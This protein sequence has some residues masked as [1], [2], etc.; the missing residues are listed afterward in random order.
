MQIV[1]LLQGLPEGKVRKKITD[2]FKKSIQFYVVYI[3]MG[4]KGPGTA[5]AVLE[6]KNEDRQKIKNSIQID[7]KNVT[8]T[9]LPANLNDIYMF[10]ISDETRKMFESPESVNHFVQLAIK[11]M[12]EVETENFFNNQNRL[13]DVKYDVQ[14]TIDRPEYQVYS[15]GSRDQGLGLKN[16]DCDIFIDTGDMYNGNK[17]QSKEEQE[18][19]I[20]KLFNILKE[21]PVT[22]DELIFIPNARVPIIRFKHETTGLRCD[23]SC[24]NGISIENTFL[25][26]KYLDMDWRVKWVIIAV[27]LWAKQNDLIGFNKFTSYALLWMTLYVL[28]QADIVIPVAHLQQLYKGPKK[29]VAGWECGFCQGKINDI[30]KSKNTD[31][32]YKLFQNFFYFYGQPNRTSFKDA[33]LC[34]LIGGEIRKESFEKL[35]LPHAFRSYVEIMKTQ[36]EEEKEYFKLDCVLC[37]QD[38]LELSHNL[39][40]FVDGAIM[41][42]F[43]LLCTFSA[44]HLDAN[45]G[46]GVQ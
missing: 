30:P 41:K 21:H 5:V 8:V 9:V 3:I 36:N 38:P 11:E 32:P 17:L 16:S 43:K 27:K 19:L 6:I 13:Q 4:F 40:K 33:V 26:R 35:S 12:K 31:S 45:S 46:A 15:F 22:F 39:T 42:R 44:D 25:I 18:I 28:M 1:L 37:I 14:R 2:S 20:K 7:S 29:K 10:G 34:P 23:I 24:R